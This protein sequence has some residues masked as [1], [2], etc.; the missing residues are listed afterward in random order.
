MMITANQPTSSA[1]PSS[2][3]H[4]P[5]SRG[6]VSGT[7]LVLL[8]IWGALIPFV[9]P[10]FDYAYTPDDSWHYTVGRL[11]LEILPGAAAVVGGLIL[12]F[13][14]HRLLALLGGWLGALAGAWFVLGQVVSTF[15]HER[16]PMAGAPAS[17]N[18]TRSAW[19][20]I[21]FFSGLGV[22]ILFLASLALGRLSVVA[23]KDLERTAE[24]IDDGS[25]DEARTARPE[26]T[27]VIE[28]EPTVGESDRATSSDE[29]DGHT[30][31]GS[32]RI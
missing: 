26:S 5:R 6:A 13:S 27:R 15:W 23:V 14:A 28:N 3:M 9:G 10:I 12:L 20:Q 31:S 11:W 24:P 2:R 8:G 30:S 25:P 7:L 16:G 29:S 17:A 32:S 4:L 1:G 21:G 19:E 22:V 18:A